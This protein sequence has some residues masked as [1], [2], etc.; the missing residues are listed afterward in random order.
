MEG[1]DS[2]DWDRCCAP[3]K[4][5]K[6]APSSPVSVGG[7][8]GLEQFFERLDRLDQV[9]LVATGGHGSKGTAHVEH[10]GREN[11]GGKHHGKAQATLA[12]DHRLARSRSGLV[13][14]EGDLR[15]NFKLGTIFFD[16]R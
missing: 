7:R 10:R 16:G 9:Q 13:G 12:D 6:T 11:Q 14:H 5:P 4:L 1:Q 3:Q 8:G 15:L 2:M